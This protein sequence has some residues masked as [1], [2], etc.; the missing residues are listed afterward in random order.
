MIRK[1]A[2]NNLDNVA[3]GIRREQGH[4]DAWYYLDENS[5]A[6]KGFQKLKNKWYYFDEESGKL[7]TV[8]KKLGVLIK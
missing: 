4:N 6:L 3:G 8:W 5:I 1:L 7:T 2:N